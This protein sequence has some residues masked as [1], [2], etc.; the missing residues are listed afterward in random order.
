MISLA[1][2]GTPGSGVPMTVP[3]SLLPLCDSQGPH[4]LNGQQELQP[5]DQHDRAMA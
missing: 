2:G 1:E 3:H 5:L 4:Q